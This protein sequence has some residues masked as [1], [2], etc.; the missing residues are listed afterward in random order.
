VHAAPGRIHLEPPVA[1]MTGVRRCPSGTGADMTTTPNEPVQEPDVVPSG[2][3]NP[4]RVDPVAPGEAPGD[5]AGDPE[6]PHGDPLLDPDSGE[7]PGQVPEST[8]TEVG[9]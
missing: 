7:Q 3:P 8:N 2:D 9:A 4:E 5:P 6:K 1:A